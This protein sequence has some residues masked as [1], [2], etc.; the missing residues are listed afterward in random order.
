MGKPVS[1]KIYNEKVASRM[2]LNL[3]KGPDPRSYHPLLAM[4][5]EIGRSM[6]GM[7]EDEDDS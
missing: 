2:G 5:A 4:N 3:P 7:D 6:T 1:D